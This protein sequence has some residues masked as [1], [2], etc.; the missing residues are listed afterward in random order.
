MIKPSLSLSYIFLILFFL[1]FFQVTGFAAENSSDAEIIKSLDSWFN[2]SSGRLY[3]DYQKPL[4]EIFHSAKEKDIP[5]SLLWERLTLGAARKVNPSRLFAT[6]E[7]DLKRYEL[8]ISLINRFNLEIISQQDQL[9]LLKGFH[10]FLVGGLSSSTLE[11]VASLS[12]S[13]KKN[14]EEVVALGT[15]LFKVNQVFSP[16]EE[17]L[18]KI[19]LSV[20]DSPLPF[21]SYDSLSL[22]FSKARAIPLTFQNTLEIFTSVVSKGGG[23]LQLEQEL[24][25]R[26]R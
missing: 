9:L 18:S 26:S 14:P 13:R 17:D 8:G 24:S 21:S 25:R 16:G 19:A 20:L 2:T 6:L 22:F 4:L 5:F 3:K 1:L 10:T 7:E 12:G 11:E 23:L 15:L